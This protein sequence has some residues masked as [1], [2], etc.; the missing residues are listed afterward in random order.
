MHEDPFFAVSARQAV[1]RAEAEH[2]RLVSLIE[3]CR[4]SLR[5]RVAELV[6]RLR[7]TAVPCPTC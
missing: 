5:R 3:C 6:Q 7:T 2:Y 4:Q 1:L